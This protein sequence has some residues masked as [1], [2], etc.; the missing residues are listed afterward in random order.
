LRVAR[1]FEEAQVQAH[2]QLQPVTLWIDDIAV[3]EKPIGC[4][5]M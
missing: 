1:R 3:A 5:K 2:E 4:P